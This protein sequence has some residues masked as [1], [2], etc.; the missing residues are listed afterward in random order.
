[1]NYQ[2][3]LQNSPV[4]ERNPKERLVSIFAGFREV[5][6]TRVTVSLLHRHRPHLF[7]HQARQPFVDRHPQAADALPPKSHS[8][9]QHQIGSIG[10]EQIRGTNIRLK[11]LCNQSDNVHQGFGGLTLFRRKVGDF[12]QSKD[13]RDLAHRTSHVQLLPFVVIFFQSQASRFHFSRP[14]RF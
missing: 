13:V 11:S 9:G 2:N 7:R 5:F 6:E 3:A 12:L 8:C 4:D 10:L 14:R 1:M